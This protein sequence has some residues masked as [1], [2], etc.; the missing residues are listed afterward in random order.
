MSIRISIILL[1]FIL[2]LALVV[3]LAED[4]ENTYTRVDVTK[5]NLHELND[6]Q[7]LSYLIHLLQQE[8]GLTASCLVGYSEKIQPMF[9]QA[10]EDTDKFMEKY[11]KDNQYHNVRLHLNDL[12]KALP[13]FREQI[14]NSMVDWSEVKQFY[15]GW[16]KTLLD[17]LNSFKFNNYP[18]KLTQVLSA[19]NDLDICREKL[20]VIRA[21]ITRLYNRKATTYEETIDIVY[22]YGAFIEYLHTFRRYA[23][24]NVHRVDS[25]MKTETY[26]NVINQIESLIHSG[27]DDFLQLSPEL[28]W[29]Q[30]TFVIDSMHEAEVLLFG[31][32]KRE[33]QSEIDDNYADLK[34]FSFLAFMILFT[35]FILAFYTV[36]RLLKAITILMHTLDTVMQTEKFNMRL[37]SNSKDEFGKINLTINSLLSYT[38]QILRKKDIIANTDLLTGLRNR[39]KFTEIAD[40]EVKRD[41]RYKT[42]LGLIFCDIDHFKQVNDRY[43]HE[44]GDDVLKCFATMI[45]ENIR[46]S[47]IAGRWGGEEFLILAPNSGLEETSLLAEKLR[48]KVETLSVP[49]VESLTCSFGIAVRRTNENFDNLC[50]RA[51]GALYKAKASGRNRVCVA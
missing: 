12:N 40:N 3:N 37:P 32:I 14:D 9:K 42:G 35:T 17:D 51:D 29:Q 46:R 27:P 47:D 4:W 25:M 7:S 31:Y 21:L 1:A 48:K 30:A 24:I 34:Y 10:R 28:W 13:K 50:T 5:K 6:A 19:I 49:P 41:K 43:G 2:L 16:I 45:I 23:P 39:R 26:Q 36:Y 8:R 20:G 11:L 33:L 38:E 44:A 15:S 18:A 22:N